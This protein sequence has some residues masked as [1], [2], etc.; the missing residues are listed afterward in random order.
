MIY[1]PLQERNFL[2]RTPNLWGYGERSHWPYKYHGPSTESGWIFILLQKKKKKK[3][4]QLG[5]IYDMQS[6]TTPLFFWDLLPG[7]CERK[8]KR[9][10]TFCPFTL[11]FGN[12]RYTLTDLFSIQRQLKQL[13]A[14]QRSR[15]WRQWEMESWML[16][17]VG[18]NAV[19][20]S[21]NL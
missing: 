11:F 20:H 18:I 12:R 15:K 4:C 2:C 17:G 7:Q 3:K 19:F 6:S 16:S 10:R 21:C 13:V 8:E 9:K 14:L 5:L 1:G